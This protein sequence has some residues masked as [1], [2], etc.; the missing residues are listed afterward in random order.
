MNSGHKD[1]MELM[2]GVARKLVMNLGNLF[3]IIYNKLHFN[4]WIFFL[5]ALEIFNKNII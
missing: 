1:S 4:I 3:F 5:I 2:G